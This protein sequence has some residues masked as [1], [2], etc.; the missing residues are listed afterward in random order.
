LDTDIFDAAHAALL[1]SDIHAGMTLLRTALRELRAYFPL[2]R[3]RSLGEQARAHPVHAVLLESPFTRRAYTKPRGYPGDAGL[4]D[5][6]YGCA[7]E[8]APSPLGAMLYAYE[9]DSP[10]FQSVRRRRAVLAREIDD[11]AA[12]RPAARV[13]AV[14][15]GH[16]REV[17]WSRAAHSTNISISAVDQDPDNLAVIRSTYGDLDISRS[18]AHP[19]SVSPRRIRAPDS[20]TYVAAR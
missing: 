16:L 10:A 18:A 8:R 9:F 12:H 3:W 11:V 1:G 6:I 17:E 15:S 7:A 13:L 4:I 14:A 2:E 20:S 19:A 5:L